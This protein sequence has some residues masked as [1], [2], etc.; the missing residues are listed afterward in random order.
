MG[1]DVYDRVAFI[2]RDRMNR[3]REAGLVTDAQAVLVGFPK[4][5]R[6]VSGAL[7]TRH[8][9]T[10]LN[11]DNGTANCPLRP[12]LL[13][14]V[15]AAYRGRSRSSKRWRRRASTLSSSSTTAH[16]ISTLDIPVE[17]IGER[18]CREWATET[19]SA[20]GDPGCVAAAGPRR[21]DGDGPQFGQF[22]ILV[23]DRPLIVFDAPGLTEAARINPE[24]VALLRSAATVVTSVD[25]LVAAAHDAI[26]APERLSGNRRRVASAMFFEPGSATD[27]AVALVQ[28]MLDGHEPARTVA[29]STTAPVDGRIA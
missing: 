28:E 2:N 3:Y 14:R 11:F 27:R 4:L 21:P 15:V 20:R 10:S 7:D 19:G 8:I 13:P 25:T 29:S 22:S 6:L 9:R 18:G 24:K 1:F 16:S 26:R 23:L 17:S 5:D 12:D